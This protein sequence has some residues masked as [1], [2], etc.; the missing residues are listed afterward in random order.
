MLLIRPMHFSDVELL[1][2]SFR[3]WNKTREQYERYWRETQSGERVTLI[4]TVEEGLGERL[5]G[6]GNVVWRSGY[7]PFREAG[8]PEINDLNVLAEFRRRG[9]ATALIG[10]C[11]KRASEIGYGEIGIGFGL[12][13]EDGPAQRLYPRLGYMPDGLGAISTPWGDVL[14]LTK[15]LD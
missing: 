5:T 15:H 7:E 4:A 2:E 13:R 6:Y 8:I 3:S 10:E 1:F 14:Y 12:T 11:E 9:I